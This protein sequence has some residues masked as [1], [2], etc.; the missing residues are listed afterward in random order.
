MFGRV[1]YHQGMVGD[2]LCDYRTGAD[3][4]IAA[5]G[6]AADD[7]AV[8]PQGGAFLDEGGADLVHLGDFRPWVEDIREDHRGAA[9]DAV[10]QGDAF[11]DADVV[12]DLAFVADGDV[13]ADDDILANVAVFA[14]FGSGKDM[15]EVP[16]F[17]ALADFCT[18]I[19]YGG[20]VGEIVL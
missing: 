3:K 9:E 1:A 17:C 6:V 16:D 2:I 12:L 15:G 19:D 8:G 20:C 13:R 7:G 10:F 11:I 4:G 5:D 14:D 18:F